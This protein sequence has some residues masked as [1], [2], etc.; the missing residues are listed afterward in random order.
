MRARGMGL[1]TPF[2]SGT[3]IPSQSLVSVPTVQREGTGQRPH[4]HPRP[5][6]CSVSLCSLSSELL[7]PAPPTSRSFLRGLCL[8]GSKPT[9]P[10]LLPV[11]TAARTAGQVL[12]PPSWKRAQGA[13][14]ASRGGALAGRRRGPA[15][16]GLLARELVTCTA[17]KLAGVSE[18]SQNPDLP[19]HLTVS[20]RGS[21]A[22][23][24]AQQ[25]KALVSQ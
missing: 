15:A 9:I 2:F 21:T 6:L 19:L 18:E 23:I 5:C 12:P 4:F 1:R 14:P 25:L 10:G 22:H 24:G 3:P 17:E 11:V 16:P 20:L 7:L 13:G 8:R